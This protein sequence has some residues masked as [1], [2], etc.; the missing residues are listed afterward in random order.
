M[1]A[2]EAE[3]DGQPHVIVLPVT[4]PPPRPPDEEVEPPP[5]TERRLGLDEERSW[6]ITSEANS[7]LWPGP[8][9][10]LPARAGAGGRALR[11]PPPGVFRVVRERF[12][13]GVRARRRAATVPRTE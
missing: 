7:F 4:H 8:R 11:P 12:L 3:H 5:A 6:V 1:L 13:A 10:A 2:R 9:P